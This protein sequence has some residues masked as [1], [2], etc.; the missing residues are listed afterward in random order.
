VRFA[1]GGCER[2]ERGGEGEEVAA[3]QAVVAG[4]KRRPL[5]TSQPRFSTMV[6]ICSSARRR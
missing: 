3:G 6:S 4:P 5:I 1:G 2:F